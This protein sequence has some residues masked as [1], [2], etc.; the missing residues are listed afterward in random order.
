MDSVR[1]DLPD[2]GSAI[3]PA[4]SD[5]SSPQVDQTTLFRFFTYITG[6]P[7]AGGEHVFTGPDMGGE[8]I[9][10]A[11]NTDVCVG[12]EPPDPPT[13]VRAQVV[14]DGVLVSWDESALIPGSFEPAG[15]PQLGFY[16]L[17]VHRIE[18]GE[19][20][21]GV[22]GAAFI[23]ACSHLIPRNKADFVE[24]RDWGLSLGEMEDGTYS[25][26][27]WVGSVAPEDSLGR[28]DEYRCSDAS[29]SIIFTIQDG[30]VTIR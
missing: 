29:Q 14:E 16:E 24:G 9:P 21:Y 25:L 2:G 23:S 20:V 22:Y 18:T 12:V 4:Y 8:P 11:R 17:G 26:A 5:L 3:V 10:E 27:F 19:V 6:M 1:V 7:I 30:E 15:E 28:G 13:N